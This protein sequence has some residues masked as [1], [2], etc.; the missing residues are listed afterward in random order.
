MI[1]KSLLD[2]CSPSR[3]PSILRNDVHLVL[4]K[5]GNQC[6]AEKETSNGGDVVAKLELKLQG[7]N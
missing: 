6:E 1:I 5:P 2:L 4:L 3:T 7:T